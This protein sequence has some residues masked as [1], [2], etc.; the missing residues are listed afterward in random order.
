[1]TYF[2]KGCDLESLGDILFREVPVKMVP[3]GQYVFQDKNQL[4]A[5][6]HLVTSGVHLVNNLLN[7]KSRFYLSNRS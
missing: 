5:I 7:K 2:I 4:L 6:E 3:Y 1:M